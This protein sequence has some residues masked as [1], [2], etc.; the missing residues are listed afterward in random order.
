M[1]KLEIP[2]KISRS[3]N[4]VGFNL[5]KHSPEILVITGTVGVVVSAVMACKATT[6]VNAILEEAKTTVDNIHAIAE[7]P[8]KT[9]Y[10]KEDIN[11]ALT[12]TYAKTG[13]EFVKL[14]GPS[15]LLGATSLTCILAGHNILNKRNAA[16][17]A[18]YATVDTS[19]KEYRGRVID[20]F[21]KEL[22]RELRYNLKAMEVEETVMD[23]DGKETTVKKTVMISDDPNTYSDYSRVFDESCK[24]WTKDAEY[25]FMYLK[26]LQ[27]WFNNKLQQDGFL[28][29]NDV[30]EALAIPKTK[31][32]QV[33]GWVYDEK[34]P[35]GDNFVDF[36]IM[37]IERERVRSFINGYER[38][39]ILDFNVD[40]NVWELMS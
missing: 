10:S 11:K 32:G 37:D 26:N 28:F 21:G 36:G 15:V 1:K 22:D 18:A 2:N 16:L 33:V 24:G 6:K 34:N 27:S 30:Y 8:E 3:L 39:I 31:A 25:N 5:K 19:F 4:K 23:N 20:R 29:L 9:E 35:V 17:A 7:N 40:G 13:L 38:N 14:Y 12:I